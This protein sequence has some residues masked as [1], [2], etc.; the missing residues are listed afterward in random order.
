MLKK[1]LLFALLLLVPGF[2]R[3]LWDTPVV[4]PDGI[5][6]KVAEK[7]VVRDAVESA[8]K[9]LA[10]NYKGPVHIVADV[11][12]AGPFLWRHLSSLPAFAAQ[13]GTLVEFKVQLKD[14]EAMTDGRVFK[15]TLSTDALESELR[16]E[17]ARDGN[18]VVRKLRPD[19]IELLANLVPFELEEP[20]LMV[21]SSHHHFVCVFIDGRI[22]MVEDLFRAK[23]EDLRVPLVVGATPA[24]TKDSPKVLAVSDE[25]IVMSSDEAA[26]TA[27]VKPQELTH[28]IKDLQNVL[29]WVAPKLP[30]DVGRSCTV[31]VDLKPRAHKVLPTCEPALPV[32]LQKELQERLNRVRVP[33]VMADLHFQLLAHFWGGKPL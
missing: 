18:F 11:A 26:V 24:P 1:T 12:V 33:R 19:E 5:H 20:I 16:A 9:L 14:R 3:E 27:A 22:V 6:Y 15:D 28:Y 21:E 30:H 17:L 31:E 25:D 29:K 13:P 4:V 10:R 2:A 23:L 32:K 7:S 8:R